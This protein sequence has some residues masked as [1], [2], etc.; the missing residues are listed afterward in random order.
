MIEVKDKKKIKGIKDIWAT[1]LLF[2]SLTSPLLGLTYT[3]HIP[4]LA[5]TLSPHSKPLPPCRRSLFLPLPWRRR[6]PLSSVPHAAAPL[7]LPL[8]R[9]CR[10]SP[11]LSRSSLSSCPHAAVAV[12]SLPQCDALARFKALGRRH[13]GQGGHLT[14]RSKATRTPCC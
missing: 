4:F 2:P 7:F 6:P 1:S 8:P 10:S 9:C 14:L 3:S 12:L 11:S 5:T 13:I